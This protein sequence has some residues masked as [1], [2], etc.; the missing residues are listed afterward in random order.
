MVGVSLQSSHPQGPFNVYKRLIFHALDTMKI[1]FEYSIRNM[2]ME[3]GHS[4][5]DAG[6]VFE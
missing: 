6:R 1:L 3:A 4:T 2:R 5:M